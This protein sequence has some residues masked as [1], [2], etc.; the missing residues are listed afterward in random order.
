M[1][2][3]HLIMM[4]PKVMEWVHG[5][6]RTNYS[7]I[8]GCNT[9]GDHTSLWSPNLIISVKAGYQIRCLISK[10]HKQTL[11]RHLPP[12]KIWT[13]LTLSVQY[14]SNFTALLLPLYGQVLIS[15]HYMNSVIQLRARLQCVYTGP[16][17]AV[18][19]VHDLAKNHF[20]WISCIFFFTLVRFDTLFFPFYTLFQFFKVFRTTKATARH[21]LY[22]LYPTA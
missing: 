20:Q 13:E 17:A 15:K 2:M 14:I 8:R 1:I 7:C 16:L 6:I 19:S 5:Q 12:I 18:N 21:D 22:R 10:A 9:K 11:E 3:G 4:N